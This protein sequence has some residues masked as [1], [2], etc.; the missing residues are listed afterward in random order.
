M[1]A[2]SISVP[3]R[4]FFLCVWLAFLLPIQLLA[5]SPLYTSHWASSSDPDLSSG[6]AGAVSTIAFDT[7]CSQLLISV[8][9]TGNTPL[10]S[11]NAYQLN[12]EDSIGNDITNLSG[13]MRIYM[14]VRSLEQV[15]LAMLLR[16]GGGSSNERTDRVEFTVP[17]DTSSWSTFEFVFDAGNLSGFDSTDFR[18]IWFYLDRGTPNFAGNAFYIDY[19]SIGEAPDSVTFSNCPNTTTPPPPVSDP[20]YVSHWDMPNGPAFTS[21][22]AGTVSTIAFD[23]PCS[24]VNISVTDTANAPLPAFNAYFLDPIDSTG[25]DITDLSHNMR[26]YARV[27]SLDSVRMAILLRSGGGTSSE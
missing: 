25:T 1:T 8:T 6:T 18:D 21:G 23:I 12:P 16:S 9:D 14:R 3:R 5:Q 27:R 4:L 20:I 10:P 22:T 15:E 11:F 17:G 19:L 26:I 2:T 7:V 24:Q 13:N